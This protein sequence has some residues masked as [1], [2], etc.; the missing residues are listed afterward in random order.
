MQSRYDNSYGNNSFIGLESAGKRRRSGLRAVFDEEDEEDRR[1]QQQLRSKPG[2]Y[3][4]QQNLNDA[5][6]E[7]RKEAARET[8]PVE[9]AAQDETVLEDTIV[10]A[11]ES[12]ELSDPLMLDE[13]ESQDAPEPEVMQNGIMPTEGQMLP[14]PIPASR[15]QGS[16]ES[17]SRL[18]SS[19]SFNHESVLFE[20]ATL[21]TPAKKPSE[22]VAAH[23]TNRTFA[24]G[25]SPGSWLPTA[26]SRSTLPFVR[27]S[28]RKTTAS[29]RHNAPPPQ[30]SRPVSS[31][32]E[33]ESQ[34]NSV[35]ANNAQTKPAPS[36]TS[37]ADDELKE[38]M[39]IV[40]RR[41]GQPAEQTEQTHHPLDDLSIEETEEVVTYMTQTG[42]SRAAARRLTKFLPKL[43]GEA[44]PP[45][46]TRQSPEPS[47]AMAEPAPFT[48][49]SAEVE[50][51]PRSS[52]GRPTSVSL[53]PVPGR[54]EGGPWSRA[55]TPVTPIKS[56]FFDRLTRQY[57]IW[58]NRLSSLL[59]VFFVF[60][61]LGLA[62]SLLLMFLQ[63]AVAPADADVSTFTN[64][65]H[66]IAE[67]LPAPVQQALSD[68]D[69]GPIWSRLKQHDSKI[70][71]LLNDDTSI[72]KTIESLKTRLPEK[73]YISTNKAGKPEITQDFWHALRDK[74]KAD[75]MIVTFENAK[76]GSPEISDTLW[77]AVKSRFEADEV[78]GAV[79]S[80]EGSGM[81]SDDLE[82]VVDNK[83][84]KSWKS[85]QER[86]DAAL[87]DLLADTVKGTAVQ[88]D[89]FISLLE[90]EVTAYKQEI[91]HELVAVNS[92]LSAL[93]KDLDQLSTIAPPSGLTRREVQTMIT[94]TIEA[95]VHQGGLDAIANGQIRGHAASELYNQVN[96]FTVGSG[97][98]I[99]PGLTS[100]VWTPP[101]YKFGS[102]KYMDRDGYKPQPA[103]AIFKS[104]TDENE[105]F[106]AAPLPERRQHDANANPSKLAQN[107]VSVLISRDIVPQH[108]VVE[109]I[110]PGA[111]LNPGAMPRTIEVWAY[112]EEMNLRHEVE[113]FSQTQ[114]PGT[115]A[116]KTL[117]EGFQKI[118][119]FT[120]QQNSLSDNGVQVFKLS[121]ELSRMGAV[122]NHVVVRALDNYGA[123]HTCF[124]RLKL[125][126]EKPG[127][128]ESW[129]RNDMH[130]TQAYVAQDEEEEVVRV[131]KKKG[132]FS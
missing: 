11:E 114:F 70:S 32:V 63:A 89:E 92:R 126:G 86:N 8:E 96:F 120:Y 1:F 29:L 73:I 81:T 103:S 76:K 66:S 127:Q 97:A 102:Q 58:S 128:A 38:V 75:D 85:W 42:R 21:H 113:V 79:K 13:P 10:E 67:I 74:I 65:K 116:E 131:E 46:A 30:V 51:R 124:Y 84:S 80:D 60:L 93:Q 49:Q 119:H 54:Q 33:P 61:V 129:R 53:G 16:P 91:G 41:R 87:R 14:P 78:L 59:S 77:R 94:S 109:H 125:Y 22:D 111:T 121:D 130:G 105:C 47:A 15:L 36:E 28:L 48:R 95:L 115:P 9:D 72:K 83:L 100:K 112:I 55:T 101:A 12:E 64:F 45:P 40:L 104:W 27:S 44:A 110:L 35:P 99:D 17:P 2:K 19:R 5:I 25:M 7:T 106:C 56:T 122:T 90:K 26:F 107:A 98:V 6:D 69:L 50:I 71:Q 117:N 123:D 3:I 39:K 4:A 52:T 62:S 18:D 118:G 82:K 108:L 57:S 31:S 20:D 88:R 34:Q 37:L 24:S 43:A 132:W 68:G 23:P